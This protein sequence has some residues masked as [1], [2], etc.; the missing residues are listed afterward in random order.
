MTD[1]QKLSVVQSSI[2]KQ[3]AG[4]PQME[5]EDVIRKDLREVG[6]CSEGVKRETMNRL[7]WRR[8]VRSC[9]GL[10]RFDSAVSC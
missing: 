8:S 4:R 1:F 9:V 10:R 6:T 3:K 7:E 2:T 5:R